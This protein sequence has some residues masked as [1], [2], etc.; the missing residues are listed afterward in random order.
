M[1]MQLVWQLINFMSIKGPTLEELVSVP[2]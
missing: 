1:N 2:N